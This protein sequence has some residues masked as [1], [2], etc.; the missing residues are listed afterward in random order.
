MSCLGPSESAKEKDSMRRQ[1]S[2]VHDKGL[3][4][5]VLESGS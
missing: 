1:G 3:E 2:G 5:G 4:F